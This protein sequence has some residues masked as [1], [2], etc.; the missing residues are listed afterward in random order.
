[1]GISVGV[2]NVADGATTIGVFEARGV[3]S[4]GPGKLHPAV[5]RTITMKKNHSDFIH[6][7]FA[8]EILIRHLDY[9]NSPLG[10]PASLAFQPAA[11]F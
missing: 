8:D 11:V 7:S 2:E 4:V 10:Q 3:P 1:M 6:S 9:R 5:I